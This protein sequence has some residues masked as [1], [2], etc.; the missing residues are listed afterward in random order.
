[1]NTPPNQTP[2]FATC[3]C[4]HHGGHHAGVKTMKVTKMCFLVTVAALLGWHAGAQTDLAPSPYCVVNGQIYDFYK[5]PLWR[6]MDGDIIKILTNGIVVETFT[7]RTKQ[8]AVVEQHATQGAFGFTGRYHSETKLLDVGEEKVP[9]KKIMILN[10][11]DEENPAVGKTIAFFA[12]Q[13]GTSEYNGD[14]LELWDLGTAPTADDLR[15]LKADMEEQQRAAQKALDV[16]LII[17]KSLSFSDLTDDP[18][19]EVGQFIQSH[20]DDFLPP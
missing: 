19:D 14:R 3:R 9:G 12:M 7:V 6:K 4:R 11:P 5:S 15:K 18:Q 17:K 20:L 10:Y 8:Q 13:T 1:M 16:H 2:S